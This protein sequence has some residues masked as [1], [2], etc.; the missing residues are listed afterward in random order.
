[1]I[2]LKS[3]SAHNQFQEICMVGYCGTSLDIIID[4]RRESSYSLKFTEAIKAK[5]GTYDLC[6]VF[7]VSVTFL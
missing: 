6:I 2:V 5:V 1:M 4:K 7:N 3:R